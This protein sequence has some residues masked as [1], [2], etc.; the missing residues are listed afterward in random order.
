MGWAFYTG[1]G[2]AVQNSS[3]TLCASTNRLAE[4][5]IV[6]SVAWSKALVTVGVLTPDEQL[7]L[8][9]ALNNLLEEVRLNPQQ[10]LESRC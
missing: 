9:E 1:S 8:E 7:R 4:Q 3:T 10:I 5:D 6:G 2:S